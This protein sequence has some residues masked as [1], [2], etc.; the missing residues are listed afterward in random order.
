MRCS[1]SDNSFLND[2]DVMTLAE[3]V[4]FRAEEIESAV[5]D[6]VKCLEAFL[7]VKY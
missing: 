2:K 7:G 1:A 3:E 5:F 4:E 6:P